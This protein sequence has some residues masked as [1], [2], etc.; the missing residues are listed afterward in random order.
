MYHFSER[1]VSGLYI[2][3]LVPANGLFEMAI[4]TAGSPPG[5]MDEII[6]CLKEKIA[7]FIIAV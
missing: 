5:D 6:A 7:S 1:N 3:Q 4:K 2:N